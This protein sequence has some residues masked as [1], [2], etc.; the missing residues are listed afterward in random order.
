MNIIAIIVA[1]GMMLSND[2]VNVYG[3][4]L[5]ILS[6]GYY[7]I[8][9]KNPLVPNSPMHIPE[10]LDWLEMARFFPIMAAFFLG[11]CK[12]KIHDEDQQVTLIRTNT[13]IRE[14]QYN[15]RSSQTSVN[16]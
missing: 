14:S 9:N 12:G 16:D 13:Y 15:L 3:C 1:G 5:G 10:R 11:L 8:L 7:L 6:T 4:M 2:T